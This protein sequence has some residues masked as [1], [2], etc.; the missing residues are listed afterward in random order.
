MVISPKSNVIC[1][2]HSA[3]GLK[4]STLFM[5]DCQYLI[6]PESSPVNIQLRSW[7][8]LMQRTALS[9]AWEVQ[10]CVPTLYYIFKSCIYVS[11]MSMHIYIYIC[12]C[13]YSFIWITVCVCVCVV[14]AY[15]CACVRVCYLKDCFKVECKSIPK[16][17][18]PTR[19]PRY[20]TAT[21][22]GPLDHQLKKEW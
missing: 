10:K 11:Y 20:Q 16:R 6:L 22:R 9:W 15:V 1:R 21:L 14:C 17:E 19:S 2:R 8:Q 13:V 3:C 5:F 4:T 18:F 7:F 12:M